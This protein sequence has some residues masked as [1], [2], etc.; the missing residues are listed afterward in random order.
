MSGPDLRDTPRL[1]SEIAHRV[2]TLARSE[3][4]LARAE[5]SQNLGQ[6]GA[7][8]GF[9]GAAFVLG[10]VAF[11]MLASGFVAWLAT[12]GWTAVQSASVT[13][14]AL[15][16]CALLCAWFG[17]RRISARNLAPSRSLSNIKRDLETL[18]EMRRD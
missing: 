6:I 13:G 18:Q 10:I 15:L 17:R 5:V 14:G 9:Y 11:H 4:R 1:L 12:Q 3:L 2:T 16:A 8:L 7:G